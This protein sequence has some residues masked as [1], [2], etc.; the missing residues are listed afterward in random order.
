V[1]LSLVTPP[2]IEPI[3]LAEAKR[4]CRAPADVSEDGLFVGL[5][6]AARERAE[7]IT[8]RQLIEATWDEKLDDI[9]CDEIWLPRAPLISVTSVTYIDSA[10]ATQ[11]WA[12]TEYQVDA[13]TGPFARRGR[14]LP[15]PTASWPLAQ[16]GRVNAFAVRFKAGYGTAAASVPMAIR[17]AMLLMIGAWFVNRE[18]MVTGGLV[19][20]PLGALALLTPYKVYV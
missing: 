20:V 3:T 2:A 19:T 8:G 15:L 12:S 11:T 7:G 13:P 14:V 9:D 5:I 6:A 1:A 4:Q 16:S 17:Q 10:G 18:D